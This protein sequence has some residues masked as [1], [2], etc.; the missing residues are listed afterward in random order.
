MQRRLMGRRGPQASEQD[1]PAIP[2]KTMPGINAA[3]S[4]MKA[5]KA[6]LIVKTI[7]RVPFGSSQLQRCN[8]NTMISI[9]RAARSLP[10]LSRPEVSVAVRHGVSIT[11]SQLRRDLRAG[12]ARRYSPLADSPRSDP[13]PR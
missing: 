7:V 2:A 1:V 4:R 12:A 3:W 6:P 13:A 5:I 8:A 11:V 10:A 9:N